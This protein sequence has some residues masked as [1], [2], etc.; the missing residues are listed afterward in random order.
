MTVRKDE[1]NKASDV[2]VA[3]LRGVNVGGKNK[4]PMSSL[5]ALFADAGCDDLQTYI[6][7]GNVV[8]RAKDDLARQIPGA[9][10]K[11]ISDRLGLR[12]PVITRSIDQLRSLAGS[13]PFLSAALD[14]TKLHVALLADKPDRSK[15]AALDPNRSPPDEFFVRGM[16][17]FLH[18]PNGM[19]RTK[20]TNA[21]FDS[22][23]KTTS[24]IRN[25]NT[26]V[27]LLEITERL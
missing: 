19:A 17:I 5:V 18:C 8:F 3:L 1:Q 27:K 21:Y 15:I 10:S 6:Q 20:L 16:E 7:S 23:L 24:T 26:I 2:Y 13:N 14:P 12:V 11:A 4:L 25:W 22:K 9:I